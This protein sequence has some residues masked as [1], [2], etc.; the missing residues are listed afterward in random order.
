MEKKIYLVGGAVRDT[1]LGKE[2]KDFDYMVVGETC[3]SLINKG[4]TQ[5]G[6]GFPVFLHPD[7]KDEYALARRETKTGKG[8]GGFSFEFGTDVTLEEDLFRRDLT[9]NSMAQDI[10]TGE[11]FDPYGGQ[12]DLR[13]KVLRHTNPQAFTED[14]LR[15]LRLA[16]FN[17]QLG[18]DWTIHESTLE[19]LPL[20]AKEIGEVS[21]E[22]VWTETLKALE[23]NNPWFFFKVLSG[24]GAFPEVDDMV[25]IPQRADY[26]PEGD[27][28]I[29][30]GL[31]VEYAHSKFNNPVVTF[32]ALCHDFGKPICHKEF[33][34]LAGHEEA[35]VSIV[36]NFCDRMKVPK[37]YKD[38][39]ILATRY[40]QKLHYGLEMTSKG[41]LKLFKETGALRGE[42]GLERFKL[43]LQA[44]EA[45]SRG[46]GAPFNTRALPE[47]DHLLNCLEVVRGLDIK[48]ITK[49]L[50]EKGLRGDLIGQA[51]HKTQLNALAKYKQGLKED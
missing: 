42:S 50:S 31:V 44:G 22:R 9:I 33:G 46:R 7:T 15:V 4:Y 37:E 12:A 2:P 28:F 25:G 34:K 49:E 48:S 35:G 20:A 43:L 29:H 19:L 17:A 3:E 38:F 18:A 1:L 10:N 45:D 23:S 27:V 39:A 32:G 36:E 13:N 5:V 40:H 11:I 14:P 41:T 51:I 8:Y 21:A 47:L 6:K 26:H 24:L 16:R 30:T